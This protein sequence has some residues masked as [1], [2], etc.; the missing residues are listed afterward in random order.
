[1]S[2]AAEISLLSVIGGQL[3]AAALGPAG[4]QARSEQPLAEGDAVFQETRPGGRRRI[5]GGGD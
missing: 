1:M 4:G 3:G 2:S 5:P